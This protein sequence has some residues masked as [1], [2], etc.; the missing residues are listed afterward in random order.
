MAG[1]TPLALSSS[2]PSL[3]LV[4]P[5]APSTPGSGGLD[6][7]DDIPDDDLIS[8]PKEELDALDAETVAPLPPRRSRSTA[9]VTFKISHDER[10]SLGG[11]ARDG[12]ECFGSFAP[13]APP[14]PPPPHGFER[15]SLAGITESP[16]GLDPRSTSSVSL[17]PASTRALMLEERLKTVEAQCK[18]LQDQ[19]STLRRQ[20][21]A[22]HLQ[23]ASSATSPLVGSDA[24]TQTSD[25]H[26]AFGRLVADLGEKKIYVASAR[27]F[28]NTV[29]IWAKQ[30]PCNEGRVDEIVKAK[31]TTPTLMGP[32]MCFEFN[33]LPGAGLAMPSIKCPQP[34]AIFDGQHRAR[35]A[36]RL[37]TSDEFSI[38]DGDDE[39]LDALD[40]S[41]EQHASS[42]GTN[43]R[44][45]SR[46]AASA[47]VS[48]SAS[49]SSATRLVT[50]GSGGT[51]DD[52][53]MIVEVYP[54]CSEAQ[55]K[56][57]YLE[58]N[59]GESVKEIDLPDSVSAATGHKGHEGRTPA[60]APSLPLPPTLTH[61]SPPHEHRPHEHV[62]C[63]I[64]S[65]PL[66]HAACHP[67]PLA[68]RSRHEGAHRRRGSV[69]PQAVAEHVQAVGALPAAPP[70]PR[71]A[72]QQALPNR[73][74]AQ[75]RSDRGARG[76]G[77][78][79]QR[80]AQVARR[81]V[82]ARSA[83]RQATREGQGK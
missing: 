4:R 60:L 81:L 44:A 79:R 10:Y 26:P 41:D 27:T 69:T 54:V 23:L 58:V 80:A 9:N 53:E 16:S 6:D 83:P 66:S 46:L 13:G 2:R 65:G 68:A 31:A 47:L 67:P 73:R 5:K 72:A 8:P 45:S 32:V 33:A 35:A 1:R 36:M 37:L 51:H 42:G 14:P 11:T 64:A 76:D 56:A 17:I 59:K 40:V 43:K 78:P 21:Q 75:C 19:N 3:A 70:P 20:Q 25:R 7:L 77:P 15:T 30:R 50:D 48:S 63:H 61:V 24:G 74:D 49:S 29:P 71:H 82:M 34:R 52:F 12:Y 28:V 22:Q 18:T 62:P 39:P 55:V 57:L 38:N